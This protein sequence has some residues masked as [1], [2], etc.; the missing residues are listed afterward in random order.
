MQQHIVFWYVVQYQ[1]NNICTNNSN[2]KIKSTLPFT[3]WKIWKLSTFQLV[4]LQIECGRK[5]L[6]TCPVSL[7]H[8]TGGCC[9]QTLGTSPVRLGHFTGWCS[10]LALETLPFSLGQC[11]VPLYTECCR[12]KF[13]RSGSW[14]FLIKWL[15]A[16]LNKNSGLNETSRQVLQDVFV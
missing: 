16:T 13:G 15:W 6:E 4:Q 11:T 8:C 7:G 12:Q 5:T 1:A 10:S 14:S 2:T 3:R 9:R